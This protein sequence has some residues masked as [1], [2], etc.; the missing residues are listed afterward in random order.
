MS[1]AYIKRGDRLPTLVIQLTDGGE[2]FDLT[3]YTVQL[4][5]RD[6]AGDTVIDAA[7][8]VVDAAEG[9]V[10]Y[11]WQAADTETA[12]GLDL[13]IEATRTIDSLVRTF[14]DEGFL[15]VVIT[16]DIPAA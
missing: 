13:E 9:T 6:S 10:S 8:S 1:S 15:S 16:E 11:A 4:K 12:G 5:A 2:A 3:G 7:M 14:P